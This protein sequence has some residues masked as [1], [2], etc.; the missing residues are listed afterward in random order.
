MHR[1]FINWVIYKIYFLNKLQKSKK[2]H[3]VARTA[4]RSERSRLFQAKPVVSNSAPT[5]WSALPWTLKE[6]DSLTTFCK[7]LENSPIFNGVKCSDCFFLSFV[8]L[9][10]VSLSSL[11]FSLL[12]LCS[13]ALFENKAAV[14]RTWIAHGYLAFYKTDTWCFMPSQPR[15]VISG[16]NKMYSYHK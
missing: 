3:F 4:F 11:P 10:H 12:W 9:F 15:R 1:I 2:V 7:C 13:T 16:R 8:L 14:P 5:F 6:W